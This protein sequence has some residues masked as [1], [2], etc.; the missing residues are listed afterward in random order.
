MNP[1]FTIQ[2]KLE[3][4]F[5]DILLLPGCEPTSAFTSP[6]LDMN[7]E[8]PSTFIRLETALKAI[9]AA[10]IVRLSNFGAGSKKFF[11]LPSGPPPQ[12]GDCCND[13]PDW[14]EVLR[15][16]AFADTPAETKPKCEGEGFS[17]EGNC[18]P[19]HSVARY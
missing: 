1:D 14:Y 11:V 13:Q 2:N 3:V 16:A 17:F 4:L 5:G 8:C 12:V 7:R 10:T 19:C 9:P 18:G 6:T 15:Q